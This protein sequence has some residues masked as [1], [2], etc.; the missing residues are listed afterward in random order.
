LI[1]YAARTLGVD[2]KTVRDYIARFEICDRAYREARQT[3]GDLCEL[4]L[5][6]AINR[7]EAWAIQ[8]YA[9][10][11]MRDRGYGDKTQIEISRRRP[12]ANKAANLNIDFEEYNRAYQEAMDVVRNAP[13]EA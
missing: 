1:T 3:T 13:D 10:T 6:E 7:G 2:P 8:L 11:Q 12:S 5:F 9:K 4:R